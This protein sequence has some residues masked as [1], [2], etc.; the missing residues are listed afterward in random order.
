MKQKKKLYILME[1]RLRLR[2][3]LSSTFSYSFFFLEDRE[4]LLILAPA[5]IYITVYFYLLFRV[6]RFHWKQLKWD[7]CEHCVMYVIWYPVSNSGNESYHFASHHWLLYHVWIVTE[8]PHLWRESERWE[9]IQNQ[10]TNLFQFSS[11]SITRKPFFLLLH[12]SMNKMGPLKPY[13]EWSVT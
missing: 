7:Q 10:I 13:A 5:N 11:H 9:D 12:A 3:S 2:L 1:A 8:S 6:A 4:N